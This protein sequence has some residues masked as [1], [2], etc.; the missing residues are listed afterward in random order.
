MFLN[1]TTLFYSIESIHYVSLGIL[2]N[3]LVI[4]MNFSGWKKKNSENLNRNIFKASIGKGQAD[5][6]PV[7]CVLS[8]NPR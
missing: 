3:N 1:N 6:F 5:F 4:H 2:L 7:I 8:N